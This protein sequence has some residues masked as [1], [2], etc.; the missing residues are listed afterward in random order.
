MTQDFYGPPVDMFPPV[1]MLPVRAVHIADGLPKRCGYCP[2]ALAL[3]DRFGG[4][5]RSIAASYGLAEIYRGYY[6]SVEAQYRYSPGA[7]EFLRDVDSG[8]PVRPVTLTLWRI[9]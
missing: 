9:K 2:L 5:N 4:P 8:L 7:D 3:N 6:D 1:L